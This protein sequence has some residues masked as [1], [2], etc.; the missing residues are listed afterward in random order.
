M[1]SHAG[2]EAKGPA[3]AQSSISRL[4]AVAQTSSRIDTAGC[5]DE[6]LMNPILK[7]S[8]PADLQGFLAQSAIKGLRWGSG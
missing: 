2:L 1:P 4:G 6:P 5:Q 8:K 3:G 7:P